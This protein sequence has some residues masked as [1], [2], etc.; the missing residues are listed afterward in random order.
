MRTFLAQNVYSLSEEEKK[1]LD[2]DAVGAIPGIMARVHLEGTKNVLTLLSTMVPEMIQ[3]GVAKALEGREKGQSALTEFFQAWPGLN[4]QEHAALVNQY[5]GAFRQMNPRASRSEA[6][7]FVGAAIH[8]QLGIP[9]GSQPQPRA[10]G[11]GHAPQARV[12][13]RRPVPPF[14]P[15]RPGAREPVSPNQGQSPF[16]GLGQ[17]FDDEM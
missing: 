17:E 10:N 4:Q 6:I 8:A 1:A 7:K 5:A 16:E 2:T 11:N 13:S 12:I 9:I 3:K 15:A 14:A